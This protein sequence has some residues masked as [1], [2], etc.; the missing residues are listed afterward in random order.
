[1]LVDYDVNRLLNW[2]SIFFIPLLFNRI[3]LYIKTSYCNTF[4]PLVPST[5]PMYLVFC[6]LYP[7]P[8]APAILA[9]FGS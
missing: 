4:H 6:R 3:I 2:V 8:H 7:P 1:M 9:V 5:G